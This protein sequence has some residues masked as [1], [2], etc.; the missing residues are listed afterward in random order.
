MNPN[1]KPPQK[2]DSTQ[3]LLDELNRAGHP[4]MLLW[5]HGEHRSYGKPV[6]FLSADCRVIAQVRQDG[7]WWTIYGYDKANDPGIPSPSDI[8]NVNENR[9]QL[10][11]WFDNG[12][13]I[14]E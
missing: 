11:V 13:R 8:W 6:V 5:F 2:F 10:D 3:A 7:S 14:N 9:R 12:I 4:D 1:R